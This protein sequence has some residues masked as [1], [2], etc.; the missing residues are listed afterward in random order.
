MVEQDE[1]QDGDKAGE[2]VRVEFTLPVRVEG[3]DAEGNSFG[4]MTAVENITRRGAFVTLDAPVRT[5]DGLALF[6]AEDASRKLC[7]VEV[8]WS[9]DSQRGPAGAGVKLVGENETWMT[10]L[11]EHSVKAAEGESPAEY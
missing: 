10:Y 2:Q 6:S 8:V 4:Y 1:L 5:G 11:I 7:D 3:V 9:R